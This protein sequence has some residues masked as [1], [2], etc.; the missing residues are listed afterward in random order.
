M[1]E[2]KFEHTINESSLLRYFARQ[3]N[4]EEKK[5][6]ERWID[7]DEKNLKLARD[8]YYLKLATDTKSTIQTTSA[9]KPLQNVK[10]RIHKKHSVSFIQRFQRIAAILVIPLMLAC[11]YFWAEKSDEQQFIEMRMN[12]GMIGSVN[13]PDGS[14]VWLNSNSYIKYPIRFSSDARNISLDGE[15][16]FSVTKDTK[17]K[18]VVHTNQEQVQ[19]EVLGTEFNV[20]AYNKNEFIATTLVSGSV[21][22]AY[23]TDN[24]QTNTLL[25]MPEEKVVY[26]R[27]EKSAKRSK[28]DV[29]KDIAWKDGVVILRNTP[30]NDVLWTLSKR[31]NVDFEIRNK[32]IMNSSFTGVFKDHQLESILEHFKFASHVKYTI[33]E[34]VGTNGEILKRKVILY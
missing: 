15:A 34:D 1:E 30:L 24:N 9:F 8:V 22:L 3:V 26:N 4:E 2:Q 10:E 16:Y 13:L 25:M 33:Q 29:Q 31:F 23:Q 6:I 11:L 21:R 20:D 18:F 14:K 7:A 12:P 19:L 27:N 5:E 28:T 17:R 32:T